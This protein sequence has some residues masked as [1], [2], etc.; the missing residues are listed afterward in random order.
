M[1]VS[2][3]DKS[4]I[5]EILMSNKKAWGVPAVVQWVKNLTAVGKC[6][7]DPWPREVG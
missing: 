2:K 7:L 3:S 5:I 4:A 1:C 6:G